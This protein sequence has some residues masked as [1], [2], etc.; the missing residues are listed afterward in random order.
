MVWRGGSPA[1]VAHQLE[2]AARNI[3]VGHMMVILQIQSM[4][5]DLTEYSTRLFA[6]KVLP[7]I[8]GIWDKEGYTDRWWP[9]GATRNQIRKPVREKVMA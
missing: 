7:K 5:P 3:R 8:R 6:E 1:T 4:E 2:E 9:Q